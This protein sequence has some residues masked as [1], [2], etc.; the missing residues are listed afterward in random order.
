M[1]WT[2]DLTKPSM[3]I[4]QRSPEPTKR[5][6]ASFDITSDD[7]TARVECRLRER[8]G[9][10]PCRGTYGASGFQPGFH[11]LTARAVDAAGNTS[12]LDEGWRQIEDTVEETEIISG[13][14]SGAEA[15]RLL[16]RR[17]HGPEP[18]LPPRRRHVALLHR[19][20]RSGAAPRCPAGTHTVEF[21]STGPD[22]DR[23]PTPATRNLDGHRPRPRF[24]AR[25]RRARRHAEA[26]AQRRPDRRTPTPT[27]TPS[28]TQ[29]PRRL[30]PDAHAR[31]RRRRRRRAQPRRRAR[32]RRHS[33][34]PTRRPRRA[35]GYA[36]AE[37]ATPA[38]HADADA[39]S[40]PTPV[41]VTDV[42]RH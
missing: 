36:D 40:A 30:R 6:S 10:E 8:S 42:R 7:P 31:R 23:D 34:T 4:T 24:A 39:E 17:R 25:R 3:K 26:D 13:P 37:P 11:V 41:A 18:R 27:A 35:D 22:E 15:L 5:S 32:L 12:W 21:A 1:H 38:P 28:P 19:R 2:T 16:H 29:P 33:P 9:W 14:S 20:L